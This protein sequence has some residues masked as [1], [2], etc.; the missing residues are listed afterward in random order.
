MRIAVFSDIHGNYQAL[1]AILNHI[2]K[3]NIDKI[4]Y[5]G[6]AVSIGPDSSLCVKKLISDADIFILG[7]H[8]HY[9][10]EGSQ[11]DPDMSDGKIKH[12][13]WLLKTIDKQDINILSGYKNS[14]EFIINNKKMLF[15]HFFLSDGIYPYE[16]LRIFKTDKYNEI[17]NNI[18]ADYIFYGHFHPG[19]Y[20]EVGNKKSYCIGS[21]GCVHY[22]TTYY[23]VIDAA[24]EINVKKI[25][26]KYNRK[27]FENR[28]NNMNYPEIEMI[29]K[30][31][32]GIK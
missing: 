30:S 25:E 23:Y 6:D 3:N 1:C 13:N 8:E 21:S 14:Y 32:F 29:K 10:I 31:F 16:H 27:K 4:I 5:L 2:K 22:D 7:N 15:L 9:I 11:I 19:R 20:D 24:K 28:I 17:I 18:D 26:L 12:N